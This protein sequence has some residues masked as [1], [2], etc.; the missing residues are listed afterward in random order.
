MERFAAA[1]AVGKCGKSGAV[2]AELFPSLLCE[3]GARS[4]AR[5]P[6][7]AAFS[8]ADARDLKIPG[9]LRARVF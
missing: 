7:E 5:I 6:T 8:T 2:F 9:N 1:G 3:I 4:S